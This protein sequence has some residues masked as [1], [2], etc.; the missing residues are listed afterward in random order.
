MFPWWK[1]WINEKKAV[2]WVDKEWVIFKE[3]II[4]IIAHMI[5]I[6]YVTWAVADICHAAAD[7]DTPISAIADDK[8]CLSIEIKTHVPS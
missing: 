1:Q 8:M 7:A 3:L 6:F 4:A 2:T 5:I